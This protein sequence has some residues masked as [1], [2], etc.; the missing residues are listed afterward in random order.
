MV[1]LDLP[2]S[3]CPSAI[4]SPKSAIGVPLG[5]YMDGTVDIVMIE[6]LFDRFCPLDQ[7]NQNLKESTF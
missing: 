7:S 3:A 6:L 1:K 5:P 4:V 2:R